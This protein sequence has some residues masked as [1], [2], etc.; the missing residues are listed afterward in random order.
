MRF[1][2][3]SSSC[4]AHLVLE[5]CSREANLYLVQ[6]DFKMDNVYIYFICLEKIMTY[7]AHSLLESLI[8]Y[9][10]RLLTCLT[11]AYLPKTPPLIK[12]Q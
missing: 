5:S 12:I 6:D 2:N 1:P 10:Q 11:S 8:T 7:F 9:H 4:R 3:S